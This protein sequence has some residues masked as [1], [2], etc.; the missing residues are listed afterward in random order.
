VGGLS[1]AQWLKLIAAVPRIAAEV[2]LILPVVVPVVRNI[3]ALV[4]ELGLDKPTDEPLTPREVAE[5]IGLGDLTPEEQA[6]LDR[7]LGRGE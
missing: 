7:M 3:L 1:F 5:K 2:R 6:M 4:H